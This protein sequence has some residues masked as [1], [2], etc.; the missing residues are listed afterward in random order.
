MK[1]ITILALTASLSLFG[2]HKQ[3]QLSE[4]IAF[5]KTY[6]KAKESLGDLQL[7]KYQ[8]NFYVAKEGKATLVKPYDVDPLLKKA[9]TETLVKYFE[10]NG[11]IQIEQLANKDYILKAKGKILGGGPILASVFYGATKAVCYGT[12]I[13]GASAT[14]A[15]TGGGAIIIAG[16]G[17]L[18]AVT[19]S[20][21]AA[22]AISS[23]VTAT[24]VA[25]TVTGAGV[26]VATTAGGLSAIVAGIETLSVL[27]GAAGAAIPFL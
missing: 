17:E 5:S 26:A 1:K 23:S 4:L 13:A 9:K 11:Y 6:A 22:V 18:A 8:D 24:T 3:Q 19:G 21:L 20:G 27:A 7:F 25:T 12:F 15:S 10:E 2:M 14:V 16:A